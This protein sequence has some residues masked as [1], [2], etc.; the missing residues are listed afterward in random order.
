MAV[1]GDQ[2][3]RRPIINSGF[4]VSASISCQATPITRSFSAAYSSPGMRPAPPGMTYEPKQVEKSLNKPAKL[5][6]R[7]S[8]RSWRIEKPTPEQSALKIAKYCGGAA[9]SVVEYAWDGD[10]ARLRGGGL[11]IATEQSCAGGRGA[12]EK[13]FV[14]FLTKSKFQSYINC[15]GQYYF[16]SRCFFIDK[17]RILF[18]Q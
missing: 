8:W 4:R 10:L 16:L 7:T 18:Y 1:G 3:S 6:I 15:L 13:P 9:Q 12:F 5:P 2:E 14:F 17:K 11:Q